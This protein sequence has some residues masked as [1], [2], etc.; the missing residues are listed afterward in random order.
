MQRPDLLVETLAAEELPLVEGLQGAPLDERVLRL[1][2]A[3]EAA[4][5]CLGIGLQGQPSNFRIVSADEDCGTLLVEH[6][7]GTVETHVERYADTII[8]VAMPALSDLEV[9]G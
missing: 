7:L 8:A 1:W 2:C 9:Y 3:R 4:S 6:E 5:K